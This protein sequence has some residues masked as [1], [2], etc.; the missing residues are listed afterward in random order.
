VEAAQLLSDFLLRGIV[1]NAV[2]MAALDRA[3]LDALRQYV[4]LAHR[5]GQLQAQM[6]QGQVRRA[7]LTFKGE[8]AAKKTKLLTAAFTA[9]LLESRLAQGVNLVNAELVARERGIEIVESSST[10]KGD[11]SS[12]V[13][14]EVETDKKTYVAAATLFGE[15]YPRLVQLGPYRL[16]SYLDSTLFVFTHRDVP[17]LI[18]FVGNIFGTHGVNIAAM[19]VGRAGRSAG[20]D[21]IGV[22][23]LDTVPPEEAVVAVKGHPSVS[24][25]T[26]V[27]LPPMGEAP[28]WLRW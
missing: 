2:N 15:Q 9:G 19:T 21:A 14:S 11:F 22:L 16:E 20:G 26:V 10:K 12:L 23:N 17:G 5:L 7:S 6:A 25:A 13:Q 24:S 1:A 8:L 18:G 4:E 3:E 27:K 28:S